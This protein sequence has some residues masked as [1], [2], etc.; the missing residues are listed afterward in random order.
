[1]IRHGFLAATTLA[2]AAPAFAASPATSPEAAIT[3]AMEDSA[4]G[5]NAGDLD[6][7]M[8]AYSDY[9]APT[10]V[11]K[12]EV[13]VGKAAIAA[14]Y[15]PRFAPDGAARRGTLSFEMLSFRLLDPRHARLVARYRLQIAGEKDRTGATSVVFFKEPQGWK[16]IADHSS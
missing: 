8:R 14:R 3:N 13:I 1:M 16:I 2:L 11:A 5:W 6:R 9:P 4:K 15:R 12:D 7:F 10:F